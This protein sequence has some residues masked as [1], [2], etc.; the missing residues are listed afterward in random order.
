MDFDKMKKEWY[1]GKDEEIMMEKKEKWKLKKT[2]ENG[3]Q[4]DSKILDSITKIP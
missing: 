1:T 3:E 2:Q 4:L